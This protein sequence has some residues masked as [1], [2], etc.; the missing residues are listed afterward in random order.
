MLGKRVVFFGVIAIAAL[1][2][3]SGGVARPWDILRCISIGMGAIAWLQV[4]EAA[5]YR[6]NLPENSYVRS[7][8]LVKEFIL[9]GFV[10]LNAGTVYGYLASHRAPTLIAPVTILLYGFLIYVHLSYKAKR[11]RM[12]RYGKS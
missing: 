5:T 4:I 10:A 1:A 8:I 2:G 7:D 11:D 6:A 3:L 9:A 12:D